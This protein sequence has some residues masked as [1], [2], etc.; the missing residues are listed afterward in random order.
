M[1]ATDAAA[2]SKP[3]SCKARDRSFKRSAAR[4][5]A[6]AVA[7]RGEESQ[8]DS[9]QAASLAR[10]KGLQRY[11]AAHPLHGSGCRPQ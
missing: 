9:Y 5:T 10:R 7:E 4:T 1:R 2:A 8:H 6:D 11:P 3:I